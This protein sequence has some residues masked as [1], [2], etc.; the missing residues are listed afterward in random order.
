[1]IS[2]DRRQLAGPQL[3]EQ[4][5]SPP[6]G[7]AVERLSRLAQRRV[8]QVAL[9]AAGAAHQH[10]VHTFGVVHRQGRRALRRFVVGMG[11]N[12]EQTERSVHGL[13]DIHATPCVGCCRASSS[14][15]SP[16]TFVLAHDRRRCN[17]DGRTPARAR[18]TTRTSRSAPRRRHRPDRA[19]VDRHRRRRP[20][21]PTP[22]SAARP[23]PCPVRRTPHRHRPVAR[24]RRRS[25]LATPAT[26]G[27][28]APGCRGAGP[29]GHRGD[30]GHD[31]RPGRSRASST[32][33]SGASPP[34]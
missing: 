5:P 22:P 17:D 15:C 31:G 1:M 32:G 13:H 27:N 8:L 29:G 9:F 30:R 34:S 24:R 33:R 4:R 20:S 28:V 25:T 7:Q 21:R 18:A 12:G 16:L 11:V 10:R 6:R 14:P 2:A 26:G 19:T 3:G 23:P